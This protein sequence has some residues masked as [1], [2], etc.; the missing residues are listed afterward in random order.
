MFTTQCDTKVFGTT[1]IVTPFNNTQ[2]IASA[3]NEPIQL[4]VKPG[5]R[6]SEYPTHFLDPSK[7]TEDDPTTKPKKKRVYKPGERLLKRLYKESQKKSSD[8]ILPL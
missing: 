7:M 8:D 4:P 2:T 5:K 3:V 1:C 6:D